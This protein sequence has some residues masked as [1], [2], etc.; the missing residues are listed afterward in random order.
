MLESVSLKN[1]SAGKTVRAKA[2]VRTRSAR[3]SGTVRNASPPKHRI[4]PTVLRPA[5]LSFAAWNQTSK[6][7]SS[8]NSTIFLFTAVA[9]LKILYVLSRK[10]RLPE[11]KLSV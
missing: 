10:V 8:R 6:K 9:S 5:S 1:R 4:R 11:R 3:E 7:V 2:A